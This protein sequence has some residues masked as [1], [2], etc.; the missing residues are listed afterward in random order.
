M[1]N[2]NVLVINYKKYILY[3]VYNLIKIDNLYNNLLN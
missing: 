2:L 3:N 1:I